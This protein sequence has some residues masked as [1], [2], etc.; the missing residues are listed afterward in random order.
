MNDPTERD[1]LLSALFSED[2]SAQ[3]ASL[4]DA[5]AFFHR[6]H[7]RRNALRLSGVGAAVAAALFLLWSQ[8]PKPAARSIADRTPPFPAAE[9]EIV[10][11]EELLAE[12]PGRAVALVGPSWN[13]Q[14]IF[15]D[16][17]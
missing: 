12:F 17:H 9:I 15:L 7:A 8:L 6:A 4:N 16:E 2:E 5:I 10:S 3:A 11:D 14:L 1:Q 13:R